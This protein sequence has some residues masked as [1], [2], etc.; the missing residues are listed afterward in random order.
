LYYFMAISSL[1]GRFFNLFLFCW[2]LTGKGSRRAEVFSINVFHHIRNSS[3][4]SV[5]FHEEFSGS[6]FLSWPMLLLFFCMVFFSSHITLYL[7]VHP[8][9]LWLLVLEHAVLSTLKLNGD[10][11]YLL[12]Q[13]KI[14]VSFR[15]LLAQPTFQFNF[16]LLLL[17]SPVC[18]SNSYSFLSSL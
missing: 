9:P 17:P 16:A 12:P 11:T 7:G 1:S 13:H 3:N 10:L 2:N 18:C 15:K 6:V 14:Q 8:H 4:L 5:F